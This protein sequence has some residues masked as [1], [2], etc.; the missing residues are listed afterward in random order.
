[1]LRAAADLFTLKTLE[2]VWALCYSYFLLYILKNQLK[3]SIVFSTDLPSL[4]ILS[5]H[6][7]PTSFPHFISKLSFLFLLSNLYETPLH[8]FFNTLATMPLTL[9]ISWYK[10]ILI[11]G[12]TQLG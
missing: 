3:V 11:F 10:S 7:T 9:F 4:T 2:W 1:M 12:K 8:G 6:F 5:Q